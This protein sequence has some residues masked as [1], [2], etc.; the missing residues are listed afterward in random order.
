M[1]T[2]NNIIITITYFEAIAGTR[3]EP[4]GYIT[5][6]STAKK[7][8]EQA[9]RIDSRGRTIHVRAERFSLTAGACAAMAVEAG[10]RGDIAM[11]KD[12]RAALAGNKAAARRVALLHT[13]V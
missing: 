12:C 3:R 2:D 9:M 7:A 10:A 1:V 11:A 5:S 13:G 8:R 6:A 4:G